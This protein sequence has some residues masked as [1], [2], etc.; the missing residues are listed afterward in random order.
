MQHLLLVIPAGNLH[1][2]GL[3]FPQ[4]IR[5]FFLLVIPAGNLRSNPSRHT[6]ASASKETPSWSG[7]R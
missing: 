5:V 7:S 1:Y 3:S 2:L 6:I 4:E